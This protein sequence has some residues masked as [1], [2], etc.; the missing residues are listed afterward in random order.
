MT[1]PV[2]VLLVEDDDDDRLIL[3]ETLEDIAG[4][5]YAVT[6][7]NSA[8]EGVASLQRREHDVCL[9]DFRLGAE[10]GLDVLARAG[11]ALHDVP[12]ILLTGDDSAE[13]D[14]NAM[15]AGAIDF[16]VKGAVTERSLERAIRYAVANAQA[17]RLLRSSEMRFRS[18]FLGAHDGIAVFGEDGR[19]AIANPAACDMFEIPTGRFVGTHFAE[20]LAESEVEPVS[21][22]LRQWTDD[23]EIRIS[24]IETVGRR[25][26]GATFPLEVSIAAFVEDGVR[27][28]SAMLRDTSRTTELLDQ[29]SHQMLHDRLTGLANRTLL[30]ERVERTI[31]HTRNVDDALPG[32][33]VLDLDDFKQINDVYGHEMGDRV[34]KAV[35]DRLAASVRG[36]ETL[37]RLGSDEFAILAEGRLDAHAVI[38]M[39]ERIRVLMHQ[40]L[41][42]N[43]VEHHLSV[44]I[45]IALLR[46]PT[47]KGEELIRN[48]DVAMHAAKA[49]GKD[50]VEIFEDRMFGDLLDVI[51]L[52]RDLRAAIVSEQLTTHFQPIMCLKT[53]RVVGL[54]A[55][56]RWHHPDRGWVRP[57]I[58]IS[59]A[60]RSGSIDAL[61]LVILGQ[62]LDLLRSLS[63]EC[64]TMAVNVSSHQLRDRTFAS[65]VLA[66]LAERG[67]P[68]NRLT[69]EVTESL[70]L[71]D[72]QDAISALERLRNN[73]VTI[74]LDDFGTGYSSL[75]YLRTL[76]FDKLKLDQSFV[77]NSDSPKTRALMQAVA[78][79]AQSFGVDSVAEGIEERHELE[80]LTSIGFTQGQG[81]LFA[82]PLPADEILVF[83]DSQAVEHA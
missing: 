35:A 12:C 26:S 75:S 33:L 17:A 28:W 61:G 23:A 41:R 74:A 4:T 21:A 48:A 5:N 59:A 54:E 71:E 22:R 81:Y 80:L 30:H 34:L 16:L 3:E 44:S 57:D 56:A 79:I 18:I 9:L 31:A 7:V 6:W 49:S 64:I 66:M 78:T 8:D 10:T 20:L 60:E 67:L 72:K 13:T 82:R 69:I 39:A 1:A 45:G 36:G 19:V 52:D 38:R 83:I 58:F 46:D 15:E 27:I 51:A 47:T 37:A 11:D 2:R 43:D 68:G 42:I 62:A 76:P 53:G 40:P 29:L 65:T 73:G 32:L 50:R 25:Q 14:R 24:N 70:L 55:L 77:R 63:D